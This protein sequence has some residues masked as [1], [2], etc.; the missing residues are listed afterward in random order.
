MMNATDAY[1][2]LQRP[3][4]FGEAE[5]IAAADLIEQLETYAAMLDLHRYQM[6][7]RRFRVPV[8]LIPA[9]HGKPT[10]I[11]RAL[12]SLTKDELIEAIRWYRHYKRTDGRKIEV[13]QNEGAAA[14]F[15]RR[16]HE[17]KHQED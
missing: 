4:H 15:F 7:C 5:Q 9:K 2:I 12:H 13:E 17:P 3:L 1:L 11:A 16:R 6:E 10:V 8:D 14:V